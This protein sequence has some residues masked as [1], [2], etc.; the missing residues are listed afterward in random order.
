M[1]NESKF[2]QQNAPEKNTDDAF[3]QVSENGK[4]EIPPSEVKKSETEKEDHVTTLDKQ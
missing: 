3:V 2:P 4:P 1:E